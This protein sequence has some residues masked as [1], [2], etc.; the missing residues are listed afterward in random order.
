M[1]YNFFVVQGLDVPLD[2]FLELVKS[3][4][5]VLVDLV[6]PCRQDVLDGRPVGF[7]QGRHETAVKVDDL[8]V[9]DVSNNSVAFLIFDLIKYLPVDH[10]FD[11]QPE[12][13]LRSDFL[14]MDVLIL[15]N[16]TDKECLFYKSLDGY[17]IFIS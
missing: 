5:E 7:D 11:G 10:G 14:V 1:A 3:N 12:V 9:T 17:S 15:Q 16:I 8:V 4:L 13:S 6:I 2:V